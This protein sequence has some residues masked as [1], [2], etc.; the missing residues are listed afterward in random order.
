LQEEG[1]SICTQHSTGRQQRSL[2][3]LAM[4]LL[5]QYLACSAVHRKCWQ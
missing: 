2:W 4:R 3:S 5:L 1:C